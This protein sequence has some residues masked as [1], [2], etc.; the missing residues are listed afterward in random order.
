MLK[1]EN[2]YLLKCICCS[3]HLW[4]R[5]QQLL[6][7]RNHNLDYVL[8]K[9]TLCVFLLGNDKSFLLF[10]YDS[11][12]VK[13]PQVFLFHS[14]IR[15][16]E[17]ISGIFLKSSKS[18]TFLL[19]L[20]CI[21]V[22]A[23][24]VLTQKKVKIIFPENN[25]IFSEWVPTTLSVPIFLSQ[26]S[27]K[28]RKVFSSCGNSKWMKSERK[29]IEGIQV[30]D[31][32]I[33]FKYFFPSWILVLLISNLFFSCLIFPQL[34]QYSWSQMWVHFLKM[35]VVEAGKQVGKNHQRNLWS[36]G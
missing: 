18:T 26:N 19:F 25:F 23:W 6:G 21:G 12:W 8:V 30:D 11:L 33:V 36:L 2:I 9:E 22:M 16:W 29:M 24:W 14:S 32:F 3:F 28:H 17:K 35:P 7:I 20:I 13:S 27:S 4:P 31:W 10:I 15:T 1:Q 34:W 5:W